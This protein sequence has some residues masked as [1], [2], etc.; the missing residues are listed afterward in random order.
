MAILLE[1]EPEIESRLMAQAAAQGTSVEV[2]LKTLVESLLASSQP[3]PLTLS[4]Q[5]RAERFVNW[6]RSHSSIKAPPLCDD[7]ISRESIYTREDEMV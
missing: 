5:E 4:P 3:T 7:A 6:A 1:L 2:L